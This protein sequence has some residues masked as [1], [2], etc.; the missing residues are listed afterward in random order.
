MHSGAF[1]IYLYLYEKLYD[2]SKN[3]GNLDI[4]RFFIE[5]EDEIKVDLYF[6][7]L[8]SPFK[9]CHILRGLRKIEIKPFKTHVFSKIT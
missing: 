2:L 4:K 1:N 8:Y 9:T 3:G 6:I 7:C 5:V